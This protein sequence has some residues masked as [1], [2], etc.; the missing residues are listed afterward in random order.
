M[1]APTCA[2]AIFALASHPAA[3]S[4]ELRTHWLNNSGFMDQKV[5]KLSFMS[6]IEHHWD[7]LG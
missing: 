4:A 2:C 3:V 5:A 1:S 7:I 6:P